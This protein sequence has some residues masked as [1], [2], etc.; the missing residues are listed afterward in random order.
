M[1][2][3]TESV[4]LVFTA[5]LLALVMVQ[6]A[7][8]AFNAMTGTAIR[9]PYANPVFWLL[10]MSY[11][12][13]TGCLAGSRPAFYLSSF[14]PVK[15]LKGKLQVGKFA[16]LPRQILVV[17]QFS[18]SIALI[19]ATVVIYQQI[20]YARN[21]PRGYDANRLIVTEGVN[22]SYTAIKQTALQSGLVTGMTSSFAPPTEVY[23]YGD[24]DYFRTLGMAF[25][26][27]R[28]FVGKSGGNDTLCA[29]LNEA[30]IR[31]MG[32]KD[33]VNQTVSWSYATLPKTL[34]IIGV[35]NDALMNAPFASVQPTIYVYQPWLMTI[36]YRLSPRA[37]AHAALDKL[38][39]IFDQNRPEIPFQY[40][41]VDANYAAKFALESLVG[42]LAG[43]F[44]ALAIFISCLGLFGLAAYVAEQRTKEIGI[45]K[46]LGASVS[47]VFF[48]VTRDFIL[49][50]VI[51]CLIA[52]PVA[53]YFLRSWLQGYYY[54]IPIDPA[55]FLL[56]GGGA[57]IVAVATISFQAVR[58]AGMNPVRSLR[59]E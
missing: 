5:F 7:L 20:E 4:V 16:A 34:R 28:N 53:L 19:I 24:T 15:V 26:E 13:L 1:Q 46:V 59:A 57:L 21:R 30:A 54:H 58:A 43:I 6:L 36:T 27:G 50:V 35:V 12:L 42:K 22:G 39:M 23:E 37:D 44:A 49:L 9:I 48:L 51:S 38:R 32:I 55:V 8:P 56:S 14:Q 18:A 41:F 52:S 29:I 2:F 45:R 25:K 47:S 33:P 11:I 17:L 31:R 10:M 3:L 40:H